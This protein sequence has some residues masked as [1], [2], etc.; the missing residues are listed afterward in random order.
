MASA[1]G[2]GSILLGLTPHIVARGCSVP[3][4][5]VFC[6]GC[7]HP[8]LLFLISIPHS[9]PLCGVTVLAVVWLWVYLSQLPQALCDC[10]G[11]SQRLAPSHRHSCFNLVKLANCLINPRV[12]DHHQIS[13]HNIN[14]YSSEQVA[15]VNKMNTKGNWF[16]L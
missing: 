6:S 3:T 9:P 8:S 1:R 11:K 7:F 13:P 15:R 4:V 16:D 12:H 5:C 10:R 2:L 14:T